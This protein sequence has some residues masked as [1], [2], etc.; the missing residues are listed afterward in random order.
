[1]KECARARVCLC[2]CVCVRAARKR[3][4]T[5]PITRF[6]VG[7]NLHV[8]RPSALQ[9]AQEYPRVTSVASQTY[10]EPSPSLSGDAAR[11]S[12]TSAMKVRQE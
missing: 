7:T 6:L 2:M 10:V 3:S 12:Q 5:S 9:S 8:L 4:F 11:V 1:M